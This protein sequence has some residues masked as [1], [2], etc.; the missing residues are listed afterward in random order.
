MVDTSERSVPMSKVDRSNITAI[1]YER[2]SCTSLAYPWRDWFNFT[3]NRCSAIKR[4]V[5]GE[6][7]YRGFPRMTLLGSSVNRSTGSPLTNSAGYL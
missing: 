6:A 2:T 7:C 5:G 3:A 4:Y 1:R